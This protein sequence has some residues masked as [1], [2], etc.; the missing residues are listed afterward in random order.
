VSSYFPGSIVWVGRE[1]PTRARI[2][3]AQVGTIAKPQAEAKSASITVPPEQH[4]TRTGTGPAK[5]SSLTVCEE[6]VGKAFLIGTAGD[7]G[8]L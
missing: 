3:C 1:W 5:I 7:P 2:E 6:E 8:S 4:S